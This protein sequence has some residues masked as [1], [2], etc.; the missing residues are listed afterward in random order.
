[1]A[2]DTRAAGRTGPL[3]HVRVLDLSRIMAAPWA[4][5]ILSD[6]G[7]DVIKVER[8][9][10]GDDTRSW[11]PPFLRDAEGRATKDA[12]YFLAVNR[13]KRSITVDIAQPKGQAI[14]RQLA[15]TADV[16]I[17][18][19]KAGALARYG[20]DA[21]SLR[22][23]NPALIYCSVTGFGQDGPRCDQAAYDFAIQAMGGLMSITGERDG[24]PGAGP[25]KVGIPI[26]DLMTGMYAAVA[27]LAALTR[28]AETRQ[29]ET[30]DLAMLDVSTA[31][32][33]NQAMNHLL[34]GRVPT[35]GGNQHPN[36]Q[37]Q[38]V[39]ACADGTFVLAVGNDGQFAKLCSV[40]GKPEWAND[41][42]FGTNAA[43]V[44]N[45]AVLTELLGAQFAVRTRREII[46]ALDEAGVP[47]APINTVDQVLA[48]EQIRHRGMLQQLSH[49]IA[50]SLPQIVSPIRMQDAPLRFDRAP[51]TLGQHTRSI[52]G[53]IGLS[54]TEIAVLAAEGVV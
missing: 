37:P 19:F 35:R 22:A 38:D 40:L 45:N 42:R 34:T 8:P 54:E 31:I 27:I 20:L 51:P 15:A 5:Q 21:K 30:I 13:G 23:L 24:R 48:D 52:L 11:G 9:E 2:D 10:T 7:A 16:V 3:S 44:T 33:A 36:I 50:G 46:A 43:R 41:S 47:A 32:L 29:G 53:E 6:L 26:I 49:P 4:T 28:A 25:Q 12:G 18:N 14:V 17:E 39:F 1:M